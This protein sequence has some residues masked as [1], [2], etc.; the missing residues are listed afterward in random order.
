MESSPS[1]PRLSRRA[2]LGGI[3]GGG[4]L[5]AEKELAK[6]VARALPPSERP[7]V[8]SEDIV[9]FSA[10]HPYRT[11]WEQKQPQVPLEHTEREAMR[12]FRSELARFQH[13]LREELPE[14]RGGVDDSLE[15]QRATRIFLQTSSLPERVRDIAP[16]II[17]F[18]SEHGSEGRMLFEETLRVFHE[19]NS[20]GLVYAAIQEAAEIKGMQTNF[21][22]DSWYYGSRLRDYIPKSKDIWSQDIDPRNRPGIDERHRQWIKNDPSWSETR[23]QALFR[24]LAERPELIT[25]AKRHDLTLAE[26]FSLIKAVIHEQMR[27]REAGEAP[28][29]IEATAEKLLLHY[30]ESLRRVILGPETE[31]AII[32]YGNDGRLMYGAEDDAWNDTLEA[33][34]VRPDRIQKIGTNETCT[35]AEVLHEVK[36]AIASS[37]GKTF[38]AFKT[39]GSTN[40]LYIDRKSH[41]HISA[42]DLAESLIN[43]VRATRDL[44]S[45]KEMNIVID[46]CHSYD[47]RHEVIRL[48]EERWGRSPMRTHPFTHVDKPF[49]VTVVQ[50]GSVGQGSS[51]ICD[52]LDGQF[53]G[54]QK[55]GAVYGQRLLQNVQPRVYEENDMTFFDTKNVE[56]ARRVPMS[57]LDRMS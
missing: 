1:S 46:A 24:A 22:R 4:A 52:A 5:L 23:R 34:Q 54:I 17:R 13:L 35:N 45:L 41:E 56:F 33:A 28:E 53:S 10:P 50:E 21:T 44:S 7:S 14:A 32:L 6:K 18:S 20:Q 29:S 57:R 43:R 36:Q 39:H 51:L 31:T 49:F 55:D 25:R 48:M 38:I 37:R 15:M 12:A 30:R 40:G 3:L 16:L 26:F 47:F 42:D 2:L 19:C 27:I 9:E 8:E 11:P